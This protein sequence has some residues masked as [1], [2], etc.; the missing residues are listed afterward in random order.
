[1]LPRE[2]VCPRSRALGPQRLTRVVPALL[3]A[4]PPLTDGQAAGAAAA[5]SPKLRNII[6]ILRQMAAPVFTPPTLTVFKPPLT[7]KMKVPQE[8]NDLDVAEFSL[9]FAIGS[10]PRFD[11]I[12]VCYGWG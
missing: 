11:H 5:L 9:C 1:M 7:V 12:C 8:A 10:L 3:A 2:D 4:L 6:P